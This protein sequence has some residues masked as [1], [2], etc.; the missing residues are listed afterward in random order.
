MSIDDRRRH[1]D[2]IDAELLRLLNRRLELVRQIGRA[3]ADSGASIVDPD[4]EA[5]IVE[6][7]LAANV[8]PLDADS[9]RR[10]FETIIAEMRRLERAYAAAEDSDNEAR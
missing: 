3:K 5:A 10:I 1:I 2:E 7:L 4:R 6:R 8:G 9:V